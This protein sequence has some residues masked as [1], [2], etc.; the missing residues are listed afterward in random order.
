MIL[1]GFHSRDAVLLNRGSLGDH[2]H[3]RDFAC[4][5]ADHRTNSE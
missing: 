4:E 1:A 5:D 2:A 3:N